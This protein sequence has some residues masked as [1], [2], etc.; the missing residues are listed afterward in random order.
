MDKSTF[1]NAKVS[2]HGLLQ[3]ALCW[4]VHFY[5][6]LGQVCAAAIAALIVSGGA[7]DFR[8]A[9]IIMGIALFVD[10]TDGTLARRVSG[11]GSLARLRRSQAGRHNRLPDLPRAAA[12]AGLESRT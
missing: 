11:E 3:K 10:A 2:N 6:R 8:W 4:G 12:F 9:F 7:D 1:S 5:R